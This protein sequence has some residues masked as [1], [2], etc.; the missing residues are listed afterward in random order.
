MYTCSR[1][2]LC[3]LKQ[4]GLKYRHWK[5]KLKAVLE[6]KLFLVM[7]KNTCGFEEPTE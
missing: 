1:C 6:F 2:K 3:R 7:E 5:K 4:N